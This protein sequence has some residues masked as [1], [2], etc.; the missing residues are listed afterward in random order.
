MV[1]DDLLTARHHRAA[2][3]IAAGA[4][5]AAVWLPGVSVEAKGAADTIAHVFV[6]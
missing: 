4:C 1:T 6:C 2:L 3:A 5:P